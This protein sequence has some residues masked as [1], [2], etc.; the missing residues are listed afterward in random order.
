MIINLTGKAQCEGCDHIFEVV[1][2]IEIKPDWSYCIKRPNLQGGHEVRYRDESQFFC[3][4]CYKKRFP[5]G[6]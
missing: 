1:V 4:H 5:D 2:P 3:E 6:E